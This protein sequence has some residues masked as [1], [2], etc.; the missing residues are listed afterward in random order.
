[1]GGRIESKGAAGVIGDENIDEQQHIHEEYRNFTF[2]CQHC[3]FKTKWKQNVCGH[4]ARFL[5]PSMVICDN[6]VCRVW[7][8]LCQL[9]RHAKIHSGSVLPAKRAQHDLALHTHQ[10][11]GLRSMYPLFAIS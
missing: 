10:Y 4:N 9:T 6:A 11:L 2:K 8:P 5:S 7:C 3:S 1:M